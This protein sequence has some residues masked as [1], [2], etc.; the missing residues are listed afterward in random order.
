M[1]ALVVAAIFGFF[2]TSSGGEIN[3]RELAEKFLAHSRN[4][5]SVFFFADDK[6]D[7]N[8]LSR[9]AAQNAFITFRIESDTLVN[10]E[11]L[12]KDDDSSKVM[13]ADEMGKFRASGDFSDFKDIWDKMNS[14]SM[15]F[16]PS[17]FLNAALTC[18]TNPLGS[19]LVFLTDTE[20]TYT[21]Q[22]LTTMLN[23]TWTRNGALKVFLSI[24]NNVLT[25]DPFH[26]NQ[27]ES[28]GKLNSVSDLNFNKS[29]VNQLNRHSLGVEMFAGTFTI[30][31][32]KNPKSV[33]DFSGPDANAARFISERL[34]ATSELFCIIPLH[35]FVHDKN[36]F[37]WCLWRTMVRSLDS[38]NRMEV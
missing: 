10:C 21:E 4:T 18:F 23:K 13:S 36:K 15:L 6:N 34:N 14:D 37:Q 30:T 31:S 2:R 22:D 1:K 9:N 28:W 19:F 27:N 33:D 35:H 38:G 24:D 7:E 17:Y 12:V 26:R 11:K 16:V 20:T 5:V 25:F 32:V 8:V 3:R 29:T